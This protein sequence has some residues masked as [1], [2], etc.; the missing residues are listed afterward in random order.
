M[1]S[2]FSVL[3]F[4]VLLLCILCADNGLS[5]ISLSLSLVSFKVDGCQRGG[6]VGT[7]VDVKIKGRR[8]VGIKNCNGARGGWAFEE[9]ALDSFSLPL[10]LPSCGGR[11]HPGDERLGDVRR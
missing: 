2:Y 8:A 5:A 1:A 11:G 6:G 4:W 7:R 3:C 10:P 9:V